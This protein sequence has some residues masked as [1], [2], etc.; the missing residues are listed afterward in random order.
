MNL[1]HL[2]YFCAVLDTGSTVAAAQRC[3]I[4]QSVVSTAMSQLEQEFGCA[5]FVRH[6][7]G[8]Q[9]TAEA[10]RLQHLARRVLADVGA[11]K[12]EIHPAEQA[13]PLRLWAHPA[14]TASQLGRFLRVLQPA[15][16]SVP[17]QVVRD[18]DTADVWLTAQSCSPADTPFT[19]L[20]QERYTLLLP[21]G[22]PLSR[23]ASLDLTVLH[24]EPF[25]ERIHCELAASWHLHLHERGIRPQVVASAPSEEWALELVAAGIGITI[26]PMPPGP[27]RTDLFF[28]DHITELQSVPRMMGASLRTPRAE[29]RLSGTLSAITPL[30]L[31]TAA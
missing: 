24:N 18:A 20:W 15:Q 5:L 9:P 8:L 22:H 27:R 16:P 4:S 1:R 3:H 13:P 26:A 11:M 25:V 17:I 31:Q 19:P 21:M 29:Q 28:H 23:V 12:N 14:L 2:Q 6:Q 30:Q 10:W 7:R